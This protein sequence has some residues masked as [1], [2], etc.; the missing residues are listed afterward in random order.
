MIKRKIFQSFWFALLC[1]GGL[2]TTQS[3]QAQTDTLRLGVDDAIAIALSENPTIQVA[4]M[5]IEKKVYEK[6]K[7]I[8][9]LLPTIDASAQY[10]RTL[11]KQMMYFDGAFGAPGDTTQASVPDSKTGIPVGRSNNWTAGFTASLPIIAPALWKTITLSSL[12]VEMA[13]ESAKGS[14][15][16]MVEEVRKAFYAIL[17][18][19]DSYHVFQQSY[20]N[21]DFNYND[22][23]RKYEKGLVAEFDLIRADVQKRNIFPNVVQSKNAV[24][25]AELQL[26]ALLGI[27]LEQPIACK[28]L[29]NDYQAEMFQELMLS[30]TSLKE[31]IDLKKLDIQSKQL[32]ETLKMQKLQYSPTLAATA[33]YQWTAMNNDFKFSQYQWNP[34]SM[35]GLSVSIPIFTGGS[36]YY[37]AK[38]TKVSMNQLKLQREDLYRNLSVAIRNYRDNMIK[39]VEQVQSNQQAVAQ[40]EKGYLIAE[41]RYNTGMAT[42]LELNDAD[43]ALTQSRL[44][45]NQSIYDYL[46]AKAGLE[47]TLGKAADTYQ[48]QMEY[49][50]KVK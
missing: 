25:L 8:G 42:L 15:V 44:Q 5:E 17:L 4:D 40:A 31:N 20:D 47:K 21:A 10:N 7:S 16:A 24:T 41:K 28:G 29:L 13:L 9:A 46:V 32:N 45:Y 14:K 1:L 3:T 30:D 12:D 23:K 6:R 33:S 35:V 11:K 36:R 43:L 48:Q 19:K 27:D 49:K 38:Q 18:A 34:Y 37:S 22:I 26:K 39:S 2:V 50:G